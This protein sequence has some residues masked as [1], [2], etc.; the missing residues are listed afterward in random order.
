MPGR[1]RVPDDLQ[2][3]PAVLEL[4]AQFGPA[5]RWI[6]VLI[7]SVGS[8]AALLTSTIVNVAIPD[9]MGALGITLDQA[10]WL[11]TA[12]LA[13]G[14]I[15]ML[16]TAWFIQAF[17]MA[18]TFAFSMVVFVAGSVM[19]GLAPSSDVLFLARVIQ[20]ASSGLMA[21][22]TMVM[23]AQ[24]FPLHQRGRAMGIMSIGTILGPALGPTLGGY[25]V[26]N[27][28]WRWTFFMVVPFAAV[29]IPA[30]QAFLPAREGTGERPPFDWTGAALCT[31]FLT[32]MLLGFSDSQ[33][34]G[35]ES[36]IVTIYLTLAVVSFVGWVV[37]EFHAPSPML[38]LRL[39]LNP[40]FAA[41]AIVTFTVGLGLYGST[42]VFPL[43][44]RMIVGL[45]PT[46]SGLLMAPAGLVMAVLFPVAGYLSD[47]TS[48]RRMI[49][50]GLVLFA[51]STYL[52]IDADTN[53]PV[54]DLAVW[55]VIGRVGLA[56][57]FPSLNAAAL[58]PL[59]LELLPQGAGA[60]N[61]L[62]QL[63]GAMGVNLISIV[64]QSRMA[65]YGDVFNADQ[66]W[67]N[68][69]SFEL[70]RLIQERLMQAGL[71]EYQAFEM[72]FG[73]LFRAVSAQATTMGYRDGFLFVMVVFVLSLIPAWFMDSSREPPPMAR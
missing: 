21:P 3:T 67:G 4:Y 17:G 31:V 44:L 24:V 66:S 54:F 11:S 26:D 36:D 69:S 71:P 68:D 27:L 20:G 57:L 34:Y 25:L 40:R 15:T 52:M 58:K 56:A 16:L 10:Q 13:S 39:F 48:A 53:T 43:F 72:S 47:L 12:F 28:S 63:G 5:Y 18:A 73:Y 64:L 51:Y 50:F 14:T 29:T 62:R 7:G 35:W 61:F 59:P 46:E 23:I 9:I 38:E 60:V 70:I 41:A 22:L 19:G 55:Y 45:I 30:A 37:W 2:A 65:F 32:T 6:V 42:Y 8:F 49:M 1:Y 33:R